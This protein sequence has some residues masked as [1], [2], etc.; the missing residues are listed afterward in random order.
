MSQPAHRQLWS[1]L[2]TEAADAPIGLLG[3]PFDGA[4][5]YRKGAAL[6]PTRIRSITP[7]IAPF[8]EEGE[9]LAQMRIRDYGDVP[10]DLDWSRYFASVKRM[11][12]TA[13]THPF[14]LFLG[15]DHS[16]TI[17]LVEAFDRL[18]PQGFGIIHIDAHTDLMDEFEGHCWSHACTARRYLDSAHLDSSHIAFIGI[19]SWLQEEIDLV[20]ERSIAVHTARRVYQRGIEAI[21]NDIIDQFSSVPAIYLTLDI[22]CLD[23]AF[24]PGTGTPE[25]GGL[26]SRELLELLHL[27]FAVL[28]IRALDIVEVSPTLDT[29]DITSMAAIKIIYEVLGMIK[30]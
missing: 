10:F 16:V 20:K 5:S 7:H 25:A 9:S 27:L 11:A 19:R 28:P 30:T 1:G 29:A 6:A 12:S 22:D 3:V 17:P 13:L 26:T 4:A 15:G 18:H 23:P 8:T 24:A 14:A 2:I 21:A